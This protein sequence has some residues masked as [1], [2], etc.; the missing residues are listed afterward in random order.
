MSKLSLNSPY[1]QE[2]IKLK[3]SQPMLTIREEALN[4]NSFPKILTITV[5]E[6]LLEC[7]HHFIIYIDLNQIKPVKSLWQ[8]EIETTVSAIYQ[9]KGYIWM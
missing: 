4:Y 8:I 7:T 2:G 3:N 1:L 5:N 6:K 9:V